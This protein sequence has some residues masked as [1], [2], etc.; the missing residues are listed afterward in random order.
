MMLYISLKFH[1]NLLNTF[2]VIERTQFCDRQTKGVSIYKY[3]LISP[4]KYLQKYMLRNFYQ[5]S[6]TYVF[7]ENKKISIL[8]S[9]EHEN[10]W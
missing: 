2:Q 5:V 6:K 8:L 3:F 9:V 10:Y 7:V 1:E 4:Q